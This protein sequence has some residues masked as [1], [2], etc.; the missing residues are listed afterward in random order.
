WQAPEY[1]YKEKSLDWYWTV[2]IISTALVVTAVIFGNV[3]FGVVI[4]IGSF[5]LTMFASRR[6]DIVTIEVSDTGIAVDKTLYPYQTIESF[7]IDED[8]RHDPRL[9]IKSKKV[10]VPLIAMPLANQNPDDLRSFLSTH[11]KEETF[12]Q[13]IMQTLFDRLGF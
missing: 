2:G 10:I 11:L 8:R 12:E 6:P 13:G 3:L 7:F 5:T 1:S 4:A 9:V